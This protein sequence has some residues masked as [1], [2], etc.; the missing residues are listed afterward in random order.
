MIE[1]V[2]T[3]YVKEKLPQ[4]IFN[5]LEGLS[6]VKRVD[7]LIMFLGKKHQQGTKKKNR[8]R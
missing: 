1:L 4:D 7:M 8:G 2:E 6:L 5:V 3:R